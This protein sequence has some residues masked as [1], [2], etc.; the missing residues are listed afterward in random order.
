MSSVS[1]VG[2]NSS[3]S[4][5]SVISRGGE[6]QSASQGASEL[7]IK[8]KTEAHT[9]G[10]EAGKENLTA[11]KS[12]LNIED[13]ALSGVED[14]LQS[15]KELAIKSQN[16][17]LSDDDKQSIQQ[18][19]K[20]YME[21]INDISNNTTYN[22]KQLL[23]GKTEDMKLA[24]DGTGADKTISTANSTVEALGIADLDVTKDFDMSKID[25]ALDKVSSMRSSAGAQTNGVD[26]A[27]TYNS[28]AALE[29]DGYQMNK[30]EDNAVQ[31]YQELKTKQ[32]MDAY[33][34]VLEKQKMDDKE[35]Q[36]ML[37]FT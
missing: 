33:Q 36:S 14:Y 10:L 16:G 29:L 13:G 30:E 25:E 3:Y 35:Q 19:I 28:H 22:E 20:E 23:N 7:A 8:E 24:V 11:G 6:Q 4:A 12:A 5:Y 17:T 32:A 31:A 21:G 18:Q 26:Y 1:S 34:N 9:K 15:I 2:G 37:L 27:L